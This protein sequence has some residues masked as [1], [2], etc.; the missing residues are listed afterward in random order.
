[1]PPPFSVRVPSISTAKALIAAGKCEIK[2]QSKCYKSVVRRR[3]IV[4]KSELCHN[5]DLL[6]VIV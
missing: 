2:A 5:L 4:I 6:P 3:I 1:M